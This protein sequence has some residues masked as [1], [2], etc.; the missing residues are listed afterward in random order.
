MA[1]RQRLTDAGELASEKGLE[2]MQDEARLEVVKD[3]IA[4]LASGRATVA[5]ERRFT[6]MALVLCAEWD[7]RARACGERIAYL[8]GVIA[9]HELGAD[10]ELVTVN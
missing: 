4:H 5:D 9:L 1:R 2:L 8:N 10:G 6:E 7:Q 3:Q